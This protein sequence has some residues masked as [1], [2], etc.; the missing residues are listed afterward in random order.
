ML[1]CDFWKIQ[2]FFEILPVSDRRLLALNQV[3]FL[4]QCACGK[5]LCKFEQPT[6][7]GTC[8][9][10]SRTLNTI[11]I[12]KCSPGRPRDQLRIED[13]GAFGDP[14]GVF[15][16]IVSGIS[17]AI[18]K[19]VG[20]RTDGGIPYRFTIMGHDRGFAFFRRHV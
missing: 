10:K 19:R 12:L 7:S 1:L 6:S 17:I 3:D 11:K 14:I 2:N 8:F 13:P 15:R 16:V 4:A 20:H 18:D 9:E 5:T